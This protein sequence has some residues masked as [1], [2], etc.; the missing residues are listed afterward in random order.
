MTDAKGIDN[1]MN[2]LRTGDLFEFKYFFFRLFKILWRFRLN[3]YWFKQ[4]TYKK[5]RKDSIQN[6]NY[7]FYYIKFSHITQYSLDIVS[8]FTQWSCKPYIIYVYKKNNISLRNDSKK[9][10]GPSIPP[11]INPYRL[12]Q[13]YIL[14]TSFL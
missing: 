2:T 8:L 11:W 13:L 6:F 7:F 12:N 10:N 9:I 3:T 4:Q 14:L 1:D 5:E